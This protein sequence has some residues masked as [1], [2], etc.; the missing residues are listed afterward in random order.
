MSSYAAIPI[1]ASDL[2]AFAAKARAKRLNKQ[3]NNWMLGIVLDLV[4]GA[5]PWVLAAAL[6]AAALTAI[7]KNV[8]NAADTFLL[9]NAPVALAAIATFA[10]FLLVNRQS[11]NLANNNAIIG[12][13]GNLSGALINVCLF[14]KS[15]ISSGKSVEFLT[16]SDGLGG[17][18]QTTRIALAASS[19]IYTIKYSCRG[20]PVNG[21]GLPLGQDARL[22]AGYNKLVS[23]A[24]GSPGMAPSAA[25]L[26][27]LSELVDEFQTG[28]KASEYAVLFGQINSITAAEGAILGTS[29]FAQPYIM[30]YLLYVLYSL[31]LLL[32]LITDL[33]PQNQYNSTWIV[34][35]LVFCT[36]SFYQVSE[37]YSNPC[38]LRTRTAGQKPF[39]PQ[40]CRDTEIAI[41][42]IFARTKSTLLSSAEAGG[43]VPTGATM[44]FSLGR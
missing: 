8:E 40:T 31:Y 23:P 35:V 11:A 12:Q 1:A 9:F 30:K 13:F 29:G 16:L 39:I 7:Y 19:M 18:F 17:Y 38:K 41:T 27:L 33:V 21:T 25:T 43:A 4:F 44:R 26:L 14:V 36:V 15:Q 10:S 42:S 5:G 6:A 20:V 37:R 22:L 24:N 32:L 34:S 2:P 28:E 3:A